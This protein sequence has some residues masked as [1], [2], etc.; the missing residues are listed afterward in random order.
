[1]ATSHFCPVKIV[2][3]KEKKNIYKI[4]P[5]AFDKSVLYIFKIL[6]IYLKKV[7]TPPGLKILPVF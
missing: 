3:A 4:K 1:M 7:N 6:K 2:T 5:I